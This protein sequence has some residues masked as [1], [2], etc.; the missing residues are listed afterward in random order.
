VDGLADAVLIARHSNRIARWAA[1]VGMALSVAAMIP[2][3]TGLLSPTAGAILQEVIDVVAIAI[4]LTALLPTRTH[5]VTLPTADLAVARALYAQHTAV[6]PL[7]EQVR[8]VADELG[9][10]RPD[11]A[12]T[13]C[14]VDQ[15]ESE[16]LP[17]E[18]A[19]EHQLLPI[20]DRALG[21][22]PTGA[23][24]RTHAEIEHQVRRLRHSCADLG[25]RPDPDEITDLRAN[26][27]GLYAIL[28]LHNAQEEENAFS[29]MP[30]ETDAGR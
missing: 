17:H 5:T 22:D 26:L 16:L 25:D 1:A 28:N 10:V 29:L 7:V 15:L 24:S 8:T 12:A 13:R 9:A 20:L 4:A 23:L 3:A 6:R 14:L 30:A 19:E 2:A 27:Y 18:R 21:P 11:L